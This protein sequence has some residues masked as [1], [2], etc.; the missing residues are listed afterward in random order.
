MRP[1]YKKKGHIHTGRFSFFKERSG[2]YFTAVK[3]PFLY[4]AV[5]L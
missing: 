2:T 5:I 3:T 4:S 1:G